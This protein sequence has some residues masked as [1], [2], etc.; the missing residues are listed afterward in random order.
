LY[1]LQEH[2][3]DV[4]KCALS[5]DGQR[6]ISTGEDNALCIWDIQSGSIIQKKQFERE[7]SAPC[8]L[9]MDGQLAI[10]VHPAETVHLFDVANALEITSFTFDANVNCV[11]F[12]PDNT[13]LMVGDMSG[14]VHFLSVEEGRQSYD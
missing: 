13:H 8:A 12:S 2:I 9:N 14:R 3:A 6:G 4:R 1:I 10:Y 5:I 11:A 7:L